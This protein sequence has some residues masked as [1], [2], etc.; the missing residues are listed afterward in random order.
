MLFF[1]VMQAFH[2]SF[3]LR[4]C[5]ICVY[6][7]DWKRLFFELV[8][9]LTRSFLEFRTRALCLNTMITFKRLLIKGT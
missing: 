2:K 3:P 1:A 7:M 4:L 5:K 9:A 8:L 6:K